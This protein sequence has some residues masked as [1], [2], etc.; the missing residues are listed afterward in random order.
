MRI[1]IVEDHSLVASGLKLGLEAESYE[2]ETTDGA[3]GLPDG[4]FDL[5][6]L[7]LNLGEGR[8]GLDLLPMLAE[9]TVVVLTGETDTGVLAAAYDKGAVAVLDK[10][11]PFPKLIR[12]LQAVES[13]DTTETDQRRHEIMG[14]RRTEDAERRRRLAPFDDLTHRERAV[15]AMLVDG[16]QAA[17][18]AD[19]S[20]VSISTVRSQIRS[21]LA[22]LGVSSQLTAVAMAAKAGWSPD[23]RA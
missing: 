20:F 18:I 13:G 14:R 2:V 8:S 10:T 22:K 1:L 15:L 5:V 12:Q 9:A 21:I 7:D 4:D 11:T 17:E 19:A 16:M 3:S 23:S 6:L